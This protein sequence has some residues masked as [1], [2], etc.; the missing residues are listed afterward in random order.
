YLD[1]DDVTSYGPEHYYVACDT[2]ETGT[3]SV[4]VNYF[5]GTGAE[6][7]QVQVSTADGNTRTFTQSLF[8]AVGDSGN[9]SPIGVATITVSKDEDGKY[10]YQV[11]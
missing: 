10:F 11:N 7:A 6:T 4:G 1:L 5:E 2:L 3:Y 8:T 9:S